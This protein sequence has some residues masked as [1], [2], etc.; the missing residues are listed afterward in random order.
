M[1]QV[2]DGAPGLPGVMVSIDRHQHQLLSS[3]GAVGEAGQQSMVGSWGTLESHPCLKPCG[4]LSVSILPW[5]KWGQKPPLPRVPWLKWR[6]RASNQRLGPR[7]LPQNPPLPASAGHDAREEETRG[8]TLWARGANLCKTLYP[9]TQRH[10]GWPAWPSGST[11]CPCCCQHLA[12]LMTSL[13]TWRL[14]LLL[15]QLGTCSYPSFT[16]LMA[17]H[18]SGLLSMSCLQNPLPLN[19]KL[20]P[21]VTLP[22]CTLFFTGIYYNL[23]YVYQGHQVT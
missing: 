4:H 14:H 15:L 1:D 19:Y 11:L 10:R 23:S 13:A 17:A 18:P 5:I 2:G 22:E 6:V 8:D 16:W 7:A 3:P 12:G 9:R 21:F 20:R